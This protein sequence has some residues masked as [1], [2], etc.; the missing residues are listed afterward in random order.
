MSVFRKTWVGSI[1]IYCF[2]NCFFQLTVFT[3]VFISPCVCAYTRMYTYTC[4]HGKA[5]RRI[6]NVFPLGK[7]LTRSLHR[8]ED[9]TPLTKRLCHLKQ[10]MPFS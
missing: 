10:K 3:L 2:A 5:T 8:S 1:C 4:T 6:L 7:L 9:I